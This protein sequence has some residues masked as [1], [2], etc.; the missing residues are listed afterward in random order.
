MTKLRIAGIKEPQ[1]R[2]NSAEDVLKR[3][4]ISLGARKAILLRYQY[5]TSNTRATSQAR[6]KRVYSFCVG[7][8]FTIPGLLS[9][10]LD[11]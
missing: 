9:G 5:Q 10:S 6:V 1:L 2:T 3:A 7:Y 4:D 8:I 11:G